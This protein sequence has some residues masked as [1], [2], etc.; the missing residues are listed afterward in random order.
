[1][2]SRHMW[3]A[4]IAALVIAASAVV[5]AD[6]NQKEFET[7]WVGRV[8]VVKRPLYSLVY[9]EN[10]LAGGTKAG[11]SGLTVVTPSQGAYFQ[12]DGRS[13]VDDV[14]EHDVQKIARS[15]LVAYQKEKLLGEGLLQKIDPVLISL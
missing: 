5:A 12:F 1:M 10:G 2:V 4:S 11:R 14:I 7:R 8:V 15:V 9:N 6:S 13:K 3:S